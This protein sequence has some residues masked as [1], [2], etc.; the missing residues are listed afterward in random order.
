VDTRLEPNAVFDERGDPGIEVLVGAW[1]MGEPGE[2]ATSP[3][4]KGWRGLKLNGGLPLVEGYEP[5]K[6]AAGVGK[7]EAPRQRELVWC[8]GP[9]NKRS[10]GR[11]ART[12]TVALG[13]R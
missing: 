12:G 13:A 5:E 10:R 4:E 2:E 11:D 7:G 6:A 8:P 9:R 1:A 3:R